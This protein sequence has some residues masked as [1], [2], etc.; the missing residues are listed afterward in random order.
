[1]NNKEYDIYVKQVSVNS[2]LG[3]DMIKAFVTGGV[4]CA[5]GEWLRQMYLVWLPS[6]DH[7][8]IGT[9]TAIS[10]VFLGVLLTAVGLYD[11][12]GKF[13][14]AGSAIPITG[15]ANA[16]I[17]PAMEFKSEGLVMGMGAKMFIIA[18]PV[19]VYGTLAS[20]VCGLIYYI[21]MMA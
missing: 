11:N 9:L 5:L 12:I 14:G 1:M 13:G 7:E 3:K 6:F 10:M 4:L 19:I 20:V 18:G 15:F 17:A 8:M 16:V 2:S 21:S